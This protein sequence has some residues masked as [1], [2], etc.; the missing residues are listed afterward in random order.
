MSL[1]LLFVPNM[2]HERG[3]W[4]FTPHINALASKIADDTWEITE[5]YG[6]PIIYKKIRKV[7]LN[8]EKFY[9][10]GKFEWRLVIKPEASTR[11]GLQT[12]SNIPRF[13]ARLLTD[14]AGQ[15]YINPFAGEIGNWKVG[16]HLPLEFDP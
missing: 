3:D 6:S 14:K 15:S 7:K 4:K 9:R 10:Y 5:K 1:F 12:G 16:T 13:D 2:S 11:P 8:R